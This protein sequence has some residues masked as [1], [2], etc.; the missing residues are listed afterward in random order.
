MRMLIRFSTALALLPHLA[1]AQEPPS[2]SAEGKPLEE[3]VVRTS[4][5]VPL[6]LFQDV[7]GVESITDAE[8]AVIPATDASQVIEHLAGIRTQQRI[9]GEEA[10]VSIEGMPPEY[11]LLLVDG[12]RWSGEIGGVGDASDIPLQNVEQIDILRG[13]QGARYGTDAGGGVIDLVTHGAPDDGYLVQANGAGGNDRKALGGGTG[14]MRLGPVGLSLSGEYDTIAGFDVPS[15]PDIVSS[16]IGGEDS[17]HRQYFTYG[18]WDAPVTDA[19]TLRGNGLWR[20]EDDHFVPEQSDEHLRR[21]DTNWRANLGADWA[22]LATTDLSG[23]L[24]YYA[25]E[26]D[27]EVGREFVLDED[28]T[29]AVIDGEQWFETGPVSHTL[30]GGVEGFYQRLR[31]DEGRLPASIDN[32]ELAA[33]RRQKDHFSIQSVYLRD[34]SDLTSWL[35]FEL[36]ARA[37]FHSEF[38][39]KVLPNAGVLIQPFDSL[40]LRA[41]WGLSYRTPSLRDLHQPPTPQL[42]G[43]YFL[44]GNPNLEPE[45]STSV[46]GGFEW[47][48]AR[49]LNLAST[50]F[51]NDIDDHIRS[52]PA[53]Q[54]QVGTATRIVA[55]DPALELICEAQ[56]MFFPPEEWTP[57][58]VAFFAGIPITVQE[59]IVSNVFEKAN[60]D[61]VRTWG[62]EVQLRLRASAYAELAVDYTWLRT[63]VSDPA[64]DIDELPNE[65]EHAA[66]IRAMFRSPWYDTQLT[67]ALRYRSGVIPERSGTGLLTFADAS[68]RTDPSY[69]LDF[70]LTQPIPQK[71]FGAL[72]V[73]VDALNVTDER[74]E[75]SYAIRGRSFVAGISGRFESAL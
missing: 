19:V 25:I 33:N 47:T 56:A 41:S 7:A 70:R 42:G 3:I 71:W 45:E 2:V 36:G 73:Y 29:A 20:V 26:T 24:T 55:P 59:P 17:L 23:D 15:D 67:T 46:R 63:H 49:W 68:E 60:L 57:E 44:S 30:F 38:G 31:L 37:R 48:P 18:K 11:S 9:Q 35:T 34:E 72:H 40:R 52:R 43:A 28:E 16:Q 51:Y 54:I 5:A 14:A 53:G 22:A 61:S 4:S 8:I 65:A 62:I 50:A 75:D 1:R 66:S 32:P 58:C 39:T 27:S 13:G 64:I 69:Q 6:E 10:A 74:R 12:Q 21:T